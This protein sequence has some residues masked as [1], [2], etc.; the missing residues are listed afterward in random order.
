MSMCGKKIHKFWVLGISATKN[1]IEI[2]RISAIL[3]TATDFN[4]CRT[5]ELNNKRQKH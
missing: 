4:L 2:D 3:C 5:K 1:E